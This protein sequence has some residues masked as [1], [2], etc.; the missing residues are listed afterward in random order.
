MSARLEA[1]GFSSEDSGRGVLKSF[2]VSLR[3]VFSCAPRLLA[4]REWAAI[5]DSFE[6][7]PASDGTLFLDRLLHPVAKTLGSSLRIVCEEGARSGCS[8]RYVYGPALPLEALKL[9]AEILYLGWYRFR[10]IPF[11]ASSAAELATPENRHYLKRF[12]SY[13]VAWRLLFRAMRIKRLIVNCYYGLGHQAAVAAAHDLGVWVDEVQHGLITPSHL[14]YNAGAPLDRY[15]L[16]DRLLAF[17]ENALSANYLGGPDSIVLVGS[18][19]LTSMGA[20]GSLEDSDSW[21]ASLRVKYS[22]IVAVSGQW[23]VQDELINFLRTAASLDAGIA[24]LYI[25]R[26]WDGL[27]ASQFE[28]NLFLAPEGSDVYRCMVECDVHATVYSTC[29]LEAL[30]L[31]KPNVLIDL[32][33]LAERYLGPVLADGPY[34]RYVSDPARFAAAVRG[35]PADPEEARRLGSR[36][37]APFDAERLEAV[38]K[39][40]LDRRR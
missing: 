26:S 17:G 2:A 31:G 33:G 13:R 15:A 35:A 4:P 20:L 34:A 10:G 32:G 37:F 25:P 12:L 40:P 39:S 7:K 24:Y 6:A 19:Y 27:D 29:A 22:R 3:A 9:L 38:I 30:A 28:G 36:Y 23:S 16:P 5:T 14:S 8:R 11:F 21:A 1:E 18:W